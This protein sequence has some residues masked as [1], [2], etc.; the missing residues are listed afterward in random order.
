MDGRPLT[1]NDQKL[2]GLRFVRCKRVA[3]PG[4]TALQTAFEP[5]HTLCRAA[6]RKR[7]GHDGTARLPLQAIVA[8]RARRIHGCLDIALLN[9][10]FGTVSAIGPKPCQAIRLQLDPHRYRIRATAVAARLLALRRLE[11][12]KRVLHVMSDFMRDDI[13]IGKLARRIKARA[14]LFEE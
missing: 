7:I 6:M 12:T 9:N 3:L 1:N 14:H 5:A 13:G 11:D 4:V 2:S 10:V 8:D